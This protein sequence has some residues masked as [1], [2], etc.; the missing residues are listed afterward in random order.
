MNAGN[1]LMFG[2]G[3]EDIL[4]QLGLVGA[5]GQIPPSELVTALFQSNQLLGLPMQTTTSTKKVIPW[6]LTGIDPTYPYFDETLPEEFSNRDLNK[7]HS[8]SPF[9]ASITGTYSV[10]S[11][12]GNRIQSFL[13]DFSHMGLRRHQRVKL[14]EL[15]NL[16]TDIYHMVIQT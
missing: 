11:V 7:L 5:E 6:R 16:Y 12:H 2:G 4:Q 9:M 14:V 13:C 3:M 15:P 10:Y 8:I 1:E